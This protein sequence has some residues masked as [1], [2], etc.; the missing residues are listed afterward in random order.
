MQSIMEAFFGHNIFFIIL[1]ESIM[2]SV[3]GA[4]IAN[5]KQDLIL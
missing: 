2:G 5:Y 4:Y 3:Y 1:S